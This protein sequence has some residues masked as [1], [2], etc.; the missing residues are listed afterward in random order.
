MRIV[1]ETELNE[2][3]K[4]LGD[5]VIYTEDLTPEFMTSIKADVGVVMGW[6][7][8]HQVLK[9]KVYDVEAA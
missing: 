3:G 2:K 7:K 6:K 4:K 8:Y 9:E 5:I 1:L